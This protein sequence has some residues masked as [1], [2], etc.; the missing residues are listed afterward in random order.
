MMDKVLQMANRGGG[1]SQPDNEQSEASDD[2]QLQ[3]N[4]E[5][6]NQSMNGNSRKKGKMFY[7]K[8]Y[9]ERKAKE[10]LQNPDA[11]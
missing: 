10:S 2:A 7:K 5:N 1:Q 3:D 9:Y 11:A 6:S 8:Q 4:G